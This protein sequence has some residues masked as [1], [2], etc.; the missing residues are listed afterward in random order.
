MKIVKVP[1]INGLEKT[2]GCEE[3][4]DKLK[5]ILKKN[6]GKSVDF[7]DLNINNDNIKDANKK[8]LEN[9]K[10]FFNS[11]EKVLF[12]G[13]DH[14]I[15][16]SLCKS[17]NECVKNNSKQACLIVFDAH[18]DLMPVTKGA[19]DYPTHEEWLRGL[20]DSGFSIENILLVGVRNFYKIE[21]DFARKNKIKIMKLNAF[22]DDF[23]EACDSVMEFAFGK[24]LYVSIDID[25]IDP[26]FAPGTGYYEIG[27]FSNKEFLF[28]INRLKRM[29]NLRVIDLVEINSKKDKN[30]LTLN[31]G[32]KI[33]EEFFY[34]K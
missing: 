3:T 9:S 12:L 26:V 29:K 13:G 28:L 32:A 33:I 22:V 16:Y 27:G 17:F 5:E 18:L 31:L 11:S 23:S 6:T 24:E 8:I 4:P 30:N 25:V 19:E 14:S 15:S 10:K 20:I 7:F 34:E 2:R 1:L 21:N